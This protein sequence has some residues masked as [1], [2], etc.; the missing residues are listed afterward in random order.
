MRHRDR[1]RQEEQDRD[2]AEH[3]LTDHDRD[4]ERS[5]PADPWA[6]LAPPEPHGQDDGEKSD[7]RRNHPVAVLEQHAPHHGGKELAVGERPVR[8]C[9]PRACGGHETPGKDQDQGGRRQQD[10]ETMESE[11]GLQQEPC[12][13][14]RAGGRRLRADPRRG[15]S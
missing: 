7:R 5:Q 8:Y 6:L 10:G 9:E 11:I 14:R 1:R 3:A 15:L 2:A 4:G 12:A 13:R